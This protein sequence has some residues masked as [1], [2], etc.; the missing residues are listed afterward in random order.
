[1]AATQRGPIV[2]M[3][4]TSTSPSRWSRIIR[5][6]ANACADLVDGLVPQPEALNAAWTALQPAAGDAW[7]T[8]ARQL[9]ADL[10]ALGGGVTATWSIS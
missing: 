8:D 10:R 1:M 9:A 6:D 5:K 4:V 7:A 2:T 3:P